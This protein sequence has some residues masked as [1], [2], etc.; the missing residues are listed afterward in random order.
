MIPVIPAI[1]HEANRVGRILSRASGQEVVAWPVRVAITGAL[2]I[3]NEGFDVHVVSEPLLVPWLRSLQ[4]V[5]SDEEVALLY[6]LARE[7]STWNL[8]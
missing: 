8:G 6:A 5:L 4:D 7:P 2:Q 3:R 1:A